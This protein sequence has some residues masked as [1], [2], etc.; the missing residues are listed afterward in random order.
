[1]KINLLYDYPLRGS[2]L[3]NTAR[4]LLR[5]RNKHN[6]IFCCRQF[7]S[8]D[9]IIT[10]YKLDCSKITLAV[11]DL[12]CNGLHSDLIEFYMEDKI[13]RIVLNISFYDVKSRIIQSPFKYFEMCISDYEFMNHIQ[14]LDCNAY[15]ISILLFEDWRFDFEIYAFNK[16]RIRVYD[17]SE[18]KTLFFTNNNKK[19]TT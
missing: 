16:A 12:R 4:I 11:N 5:R 15:I 14:K 13:N 10:K 3:E 17:S 6:F 9:E 19:A 8:I 2:T 7:D 18:K 1:M